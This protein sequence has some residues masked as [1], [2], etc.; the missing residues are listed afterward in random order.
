MLNDF[1]LSAVS[2]SLSYSLFSRLRE[3]ILNGK[4]PDGEKLTEQKICEEYHVSRTPVREAFKQLE[5]EGLLSNIPNRGAFISSFS[6]R[7]IDD[8]YELRKSGEILAVQWGIA[9][10]TPEELEELKEAYEFMEFYTLRR[11]Y[12]KMLNMNAKFHDMIYTASHNRFLAQ[13]LPLYQLY[14]KQMSALGNYNDQDLIKVLAE[15]KDIVDAFI[16]KD[17]SKGIAV[18]GMHLDNAR[19]RATIK[20]AQNPLP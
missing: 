10:I 7:D 14:V 12:T 6:P 1:D 2:P 20:V 19:K 17:V 13:T 8:L 4:L 11:D 16:N 18:M 15:H 9:R 3:D 5:L